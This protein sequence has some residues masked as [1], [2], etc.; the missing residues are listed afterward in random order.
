MHG[1]STRKFVYSLYNLY[2]RIVCAASFQTKQ[3]RERERRKG[4]EQRLTRLSAQ[5]LEKMGR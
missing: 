2:A 1:T 3:K 5:D 4:I